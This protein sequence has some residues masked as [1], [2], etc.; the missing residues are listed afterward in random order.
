MQFGLAG[1]KG[2]PSGPVRLLLSSG[3]LEIGQQVL[4]FQVITQ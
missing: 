4:E 1:C 2:W 3:F